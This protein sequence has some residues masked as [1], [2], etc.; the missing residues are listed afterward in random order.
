MYASP[1]IF[2]LHDNA[3]IVT[4][5]NETSDLLS[6]L[7]SLQPREGTHSGGSNELI[8]EQMLKLIENKLPESFNI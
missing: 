4:Y 6:T 7:L 8:V 5:Q 1:E 3:E 2:G